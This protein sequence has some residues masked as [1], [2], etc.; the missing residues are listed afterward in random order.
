VTYAAAV[1]NRQQALLQET[2]LLRGALR[3]PLATGAAALSALTLPVGLIQLLAFGP[4]FI[5]EVPDWVPRWVGS[6]IV[7]FFGLFWAL[8]IFV[9]FDAIIQG[10][11]RRASD[12]R[13]SAQGVR[14]IGGPANGLSLG[15]DDVHD[16][17]VE[18]GLWLSGREVA[19][20]S[21]PD[22]LRSFAAIAETVRSLRQPASPQ[23]DAGPRL[24]HCPTCGAPAAPSPTPQPLCRFCRTPVPMPT[25]VQTRFAALD[26]LGR[27]RQ[28]TERLLRA[29]LRQRGASFTNAVLALA[30]P[31]LLLGLPLT[32]LL[33]NEL[34]VVRH[35]LHNAHA[36]WLFPFAVCFTYGLLIWLHGQVVGRAAIRLVALRYRARP[37]RR[38]E[39][40]WSCRLCAA[41]LP[42]A[43]GQLILL[44]LYCQAENLTGIDLREDSAQLEAQ[45]GELAATL[46]ERLRQRRRWRFLSLAAAVLLALSVGALAGAFPRTCRDGLHNGNETDKDCGG[47]CLRCQ[48]GKHCQGATDCISGICSG[49]SCATPS[50]RDGVKNGDESDVDCGGQ[51]A[52]CQAGYFCLRST[53]CQG[54]R[55]AL[56]G[57]CQ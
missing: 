9:V 37:P 17:K 56:T 19:R 23:A 15:W 55:C 1:L 8:W 3:M 57:R 47:A 11:R 32:A 7:V 31:P 18:D 39:E 43:P 53:D 46:Q 30:I 42:D 52:P 45:A 49:G 54:G 12:V 48:P 2:S 5:S 26:Q 40:P 36:L 13:F 28:H 16:C 50:C 21:E 44:C 20:S 22:E 4:F 33:F 27:S 6:V 41:P 35:L 38:Q 51:C 34:R 25:E 14:V 24:L 29:L 10:W